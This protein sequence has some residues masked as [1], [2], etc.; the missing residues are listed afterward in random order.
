MGRDREGTGKPSLRKGELH[1][2]LNEELTGPKVG[3]GAPQA[4]GTAYTKP[5]QG[6]KAQDCQQ[7]GLGGR[8]GTTPRGPGSLGL[9]L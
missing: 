1:L 6:A 5:V 4:G 8:A 3:R 7:A 9:S 2:R